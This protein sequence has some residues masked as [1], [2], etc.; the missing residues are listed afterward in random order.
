MSN[1]ELVF[2][3]IV[4]TIKLGHVDPEFSVLQSALSKTR[5]TF[6]TRAM[7][8]FYI[9]DCQLKGVKKGKDQPYRC[10]FLR[11]GER[12]ELLPNRPKPGNFWQ[13]LLMYE[14]FRVWQCHATP[15]GFLLIQTLPLNFKSHQIL[16]T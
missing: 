11:E 7:C 6:R 12:V 8:S 15:S 16:D 9:I 1:G 14:S 3:N 10:P 13:C 2:P 4:H 5:D